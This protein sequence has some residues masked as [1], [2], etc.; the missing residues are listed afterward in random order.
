MIY[1]LIKRINYY[2]KKRNNLVNT[3]LKMKRWLHKKLIKK[4]VLIQI[5]NNLKKCRNRIVKKMPCGYI[6]SMKTII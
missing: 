3:K 1:I 6:L 4:A 2:K 5:Q